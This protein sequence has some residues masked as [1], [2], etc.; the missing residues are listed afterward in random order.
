P[1]SIFYN[2]STTLSDALSYGVLLR[3]ICSLGGTPYPGMMVDSTF[4]NKIK[5]GY[6]MAKP[7]HAT[8]EVY[9]IMVQCWNSEPEKR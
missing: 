9:E 2:L 4:Y 5:S 3:E 7:D 1:A 8:S 6:R